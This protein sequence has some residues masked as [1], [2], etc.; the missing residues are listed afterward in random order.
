MQNDTRIYGLCLLLFLT[1]HV[2]SGT[3]PEVRDKANAPDHLQ[4]VFN[5]QD[6]WGSRRATQRIQLLRRSLEPHSGMKPSLASRVASKTDPALIIASFD[7]FPASEEWQD[8]SSQGVQFLTY[9]SHRHWLIRVVIPIPAAFALTGATSFSEF[10]QADKVSIALDGYQAQPAFYDAEANLVVL[11]LTLADSD[12]KV[13][14]ALRALYH[15]P[16]KAFMDQSGGRHL[17]LVTFPKNIAKLA[18]LPSVLKISP[19]AWEPLLLMDG[20]RTVVHGDTVIGK[21][22]MVL[23]GNQIRMAN[24]ERM[25]P[26]ADHEDFWEH[27]PA[28]NPTVPRFTPLAIAEC[29]GSSA[30]NPHAQM[31]TGIM[32]GNGWQSANNGGA[33]FG[34]RGMAPQAIF[35]CYDNDNAK[36]HVSSHSYVSAASPLN[37]F[38]DAAVVGSIAPQVFHAHTAAAGNSGLTDKGFNDE[39][40]YF[41]IQNNSKN[42][43]VVA[44]AQINGHIHPE[45]SSGP[46]HDG[47]IK[48]DIA[49]P[50]QNYRQDLDQQGFTVEIEKME[51]L[52]NGSPLYT[53]EFDGNGLLWHQ[54]WGDTD[55][56]DYFGQVFLSASQTA[57]GNLLLDIDPKPWGTKWIR[58]PVVGTQVVPYNDRTGG[59][60][61]LNF[62]GQENDV[63]KI[64]YRAVL[65]SYSENLGYF[66]MWP[67][68]FRSFPPVDCGWYSQGAHGGSGIGD[69]QWRTLEIPVGRG[70]DIFLDG[71][72]CFSGDETWNGKSIQYLGLRFL[73]V[74]SQPTPTFP[75]YY[76]GSGGTSGASPVAAGAYALAM[77]HLTQLYHQVDLD[78]KSRDSAYVGGANPPFGMPSNATWKAIFMHTARDLNDSQNGPVPP[79]FPSNPDTG[80]PVSYYDGPDFTTG[81][82]MLNVQSGI[83]LMTRTAENDPLYRVIEAE[84][85]SGQYHT[86]ALSVPDSFVGDLDGLKV[87]LAWDDEPAYGATSQIE[88]KLVNNLGLVLEDPNGKMFYPW[89]VD[90]P[91]E[92]GEMDGPHVLEPE[93]IMDK[94]IVPA[95]RDMPNDR[96]NLEQVQVDVLSGE[97]SGIWLLHVVDNGMGAPQNGQKYTLVVSPWQV[98]GQCHICPGP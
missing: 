72:M 12:F 31:T 90:L 13:H 55:N 87:T 78:E 69:G 34:F 18:A 93:P 20:V 75:Q 81:Y 33:P 74:D 57:T 32:L 73:R 7:R 43:L 8:W 45:S 84:I 50:T 80:E 42:V 5:T 65:S 98:K 91:Y 83:D 23:T 51:L 1:C 35:E 61:P 85:D 40:G 27:D 97:Q 46:T 96:D 86:Y 59:G 30:A 67:V 2:Q 60:N 54:G 14:A 15:R 39:K 11:E 16:G 10:Q 29:I 28:G 36:A 47:R 44:N 58:S 56:V 17:T 88:P 95:R 48:P 22:G 9:L 76:Q 53:W 19:G 63:L 92:Y 25:G 66:D 79:D 62:I 82:G 94:N 77:E 89:S 24:K 4:A 68:W 21:N 49:A 3:V 37:T 26:G 41:S 64:R 6:D 38:W 71:N 70:M 52:R